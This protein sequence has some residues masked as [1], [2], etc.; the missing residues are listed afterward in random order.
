[1]GLLLKVDVREK[2]LISILQKLEKE[3]K[4]GI[5]IEVETLDLGDAIIVDD[6]TNKDLVIIERKS[7]SDLASSI[8]DGRYREQ[9]YRLN[10]NEVHNHNIVYVIEGDVDV[11]CKYMAN[12]RYK[13]MD[14][15]TLYSKFESQLCCF[16]IFEN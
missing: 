14:A 7:I 4:T 1:M 16:W 12:S 2:K 10:A 9:S 8:K 3:R 5:K 6:K 13:G 15:N 11:Y